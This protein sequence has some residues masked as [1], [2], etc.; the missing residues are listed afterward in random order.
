MILVAAV[1]DRLGIGFNHR[2]QSRDEALRRDLIRE[3]AGA[4]IWMSAYSLRQFKDE[5]AQAD[6]RNSENFLFDANDG[7]FCF[8]ENILVSTVENRAERIILYRWN[9]TYPA[10]I[11]FDI[12]LSAGWF[13]AESM[14]FAGKSHEK[15]TKEVYLREQE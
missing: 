13:L 3:A 9:R 12:D 2:R 4:P 7:E 6:L 10:D 14:D 5:A 15:I 11:Y 1:D 8:A